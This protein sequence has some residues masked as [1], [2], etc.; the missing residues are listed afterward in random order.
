MPAFIVWTQT[1][2]DD[3]RDARRIN[4]RTQY[5]ALH[6]GA[7]LNGER[8]T[9]RTMVIDPHDCADLFEMLRLEKRDTLRMTLA[10]LVEQSLAEE[11]TLERLHARRREQG[12]LERDEESEYSRLMDMHA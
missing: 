6:Q 9:A 11:A 7:I 1:H 3:A 2:N 12:S 5:E 4:A 10:G 8:T